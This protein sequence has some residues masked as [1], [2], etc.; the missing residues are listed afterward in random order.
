MG[1]GG[2]LGWLKRGHVM[3]LPST[4]VL[5]KRVLHVLAAL[6]IRLPP[7]D[8][9]APSPW[10][11]RIQ[12]R[13]PDPDPPSAD[14][15]RSTY[16]YSHVCLERAATLDYAPNPRRAK[17]VVL[18]PLWPVRLGGSPAPGSSPVHAVCQ[19][20]TSAWPSSWQSSRTRMDSSS[21]S[22][23]KHGLPFLLV[24]I[25]TPCSDLGPQSP[26]DATLHMASFSAQA[27]ACDVEMGVHE[28][29][30]LLAFFGVF[31]GR[32]AA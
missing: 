3:M 8:R 1:L 5:Y 9:L 13:C 12:G 18:S 15:V 31:H 17:A 20:H 16:Y 4:Q 27:M 19:A 14:H 2:A 22:T 23:G 7:P 28:P 29:P 25:V 11:P 21:T 26:D 6:N 24:R 30:L 10:R 32:G